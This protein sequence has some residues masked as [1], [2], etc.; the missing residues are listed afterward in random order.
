MSL[1]FGSW[2]FSF[3][4]Y[5]LQSVNHLINNNLFGYYRYFSK[6]KLKYNFPGYIFF[7]CRES[8]RSIAIEPGKSYVNK[9]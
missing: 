3:G 1:E 5:I 4:I 2:N 7:G 6:N 9:T 8:I